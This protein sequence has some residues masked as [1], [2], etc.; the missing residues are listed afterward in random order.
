[1]P[2]LRNNQTIASLKKIT[3]LVNQTTQSSPKCQELRRGEIKDDFR[4]G[5]EL[6][7]NWEGRYQIANVQ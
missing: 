2:F 6:H 5:T 7:L 3:A 1:M 4:Q